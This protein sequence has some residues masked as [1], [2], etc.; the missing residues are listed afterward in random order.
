MRKLIIFLILLFSGSVFADT[1]PAHST[2]SNYYNGVVYS[3][4]VSMSDL[5]SKMPT[6]LG[7]AP[8]FNPSPPQCAVYT[9]YGFTFVTINNYLTCPYGGTVSGSDCINAPSCTAP[10]VR[11]ATTGMCETPPPATCQ[12]TPTT[13]T[14]GSTQT[15]SWETLNT[16]SNTCDPHSLN[17]DYPLAVNATT[18]QCDLTCSDGSTVDVSAGAQCPPP[19]CP[20][21][22]NGN[23]ITKQAWNSVTQ[24][25]ENSDI[26]YCD[27]QL[28][29]PDAGTGT[30]LPKPGAIDCGNGI[31]VISPLVCSSEPDHSQDITCP[32]G[33]IISPPRTC[34]L[35]PPD[36]ANCPG[37]ASAVETTG[38]VNG[39]PTCVM[40]DGTTTA[41]ADGSQSPADDKYNPQNYKAGVACNASNSYPCDPSLPVVSAPGLTGIEK[42]GPGTFFTCV[43]KHDKPVAPALHPASPSPTTSATTTTG[44]ST[45]IITNSDGSTSTQT[46][47]T[48][49]TG[50][51][52]TTGAT[53]TD[54]PDCAKESTLREIV[55]RIGKSSR[56][57]SV[58]QP[59]NGTGPPSDTNADEILSKKAAVSSMI[60]DIKSQMSG[61]MPSVSG[62]AS[63]SC[64]GGVYVMGITFNICLAPY[65]EQLS[66]IG[67][68]VYVAA[69]VFS[70]MII[71]G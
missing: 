39:V 52:T 8:Y 65:T 71:L 24:K 28:Q 3:S 62:G 10:Q 31:V 68:G 57:G 41:A 67:I 59:G 70:V 40:K 20:N 48:N 58:W 42:C 16:S 53:T 14:S 35:L 27:G 64:D 55:D 44:T 47:T 34:A 29:V 66:K 30:C 7:T 17:C 15:L 32:D 1:Y 18:K 37:G 54:C 33:L 56:S 38:Y 12:T 43:D 11:N 21:Q 5:C 26:V 45:T 6:V 22:V 61:L 2:Y 36:P 50:T 63:I 46:S 4:T 60:F 23:M 51:T 13:T 49:N 19:S 9:Q 69:I 25:C